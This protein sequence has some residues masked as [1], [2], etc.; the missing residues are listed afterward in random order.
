MSYKHRFAFNGGGEDN[1][2]GE[3]ALATY[4]ALAKSIVGEVRQRSNQFN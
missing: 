3:R 1:K 2:G 4:S